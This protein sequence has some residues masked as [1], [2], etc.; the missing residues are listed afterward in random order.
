M[1]VAQSEQ[2]SVPAALLKRPVAHCLH[3]PALVTPQPEWNSPTVH[4]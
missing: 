2:P 1:P 3:E 4:S